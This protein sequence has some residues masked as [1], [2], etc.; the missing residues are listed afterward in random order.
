MRPQ[1]KSQHCKALTKEQREVLDEAALK[2]GTDWYVRPGK[3]HNKIYVGERLVTVVSFSKDRNNRASTNPATR[4]RVQIE[5]AMKGS[6][7]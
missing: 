6:E 3:Q 1:M 5:Q 4:L 7:R 2:Y